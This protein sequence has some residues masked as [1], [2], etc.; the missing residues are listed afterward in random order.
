MSRAA[1][2]PRKPGRPLLGARPKIRINIMLDPAVA[3]RL[4]A[5]GDGNLSAGIEIA[6]KRRTK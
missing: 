1:K 6:E 4:R 2:A 3:A 5:L